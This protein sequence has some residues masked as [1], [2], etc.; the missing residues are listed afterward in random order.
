MRS[1]TEKV[2]GELWLDRFG[3]Y[4]YRLPWR[5]SKV[6][7]RPNMPDT[8]LPSI[9][10]MARVRTFRTWVEEDRDELESVLQR[11]EA[12]LVE[13]KDMDR[14]P[15]PEGYIVYLR[16]REL[17]LAPRDYTGPEDTPAIE[18]LDQGAPIETDEPEGSRMIDREVSEEEPEDKPIGANPEV[19]E[20][21]KSESFDAP[22]AVYKLGDEE[23][24]AAD[25][26]EYDEPDELAPPGL[27]DRKPL[28][29]I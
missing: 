19:E 15:T 5:G 2:A 20:V 17:Y 18:G 22:I 4:Y 10:G 13:V 12:F 27:T 11:E 9:R 21:E 14:H 16:W 6:P 8:K 26:Y 29:E 23:S 3:E 24:P 25:D 1:P 7:I 28:P